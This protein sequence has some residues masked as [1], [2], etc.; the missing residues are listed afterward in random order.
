MTG[1]RII[2]ID[3]RRDLVAIYRAELVRVGYTVPEIDDDAELLRVYFGVCRRLVPSQPRQILKAKGFQCS[4]EHYA[5]LTQIEQLI[6]DGG[7]ITPYLSRSIKKVKYNDALL[8]DWGIHHLHLGTDLQSDGFVNRDGPLL[9]CRF[10]NKHAYFITILPHGSWAK[11]KLV[12]TI[13]DNWPAQIDRYRASGIKGVTPNR[14][15]D[16]DIAALRKVTVSGFIELEDGPVYLPIG[17]GTV[18]SG[19]NILDVRQADMCLDWAERM[20]RKIID[21]FPEIEARARERGVLFP[22]PAVLKMV[23]AEGSFWAVEM[24]SAYGLLL[25][26]P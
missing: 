22:E 12:K 5:A 24:G 9:F 17:G 1:T 4:P 16:D 19:K 23:I 2:D 13:H 18:S 8:N 3:L 11:Q 14:L 7:D 6:Q 10:D 25:E 21:D 20:Q 26:S 15:S